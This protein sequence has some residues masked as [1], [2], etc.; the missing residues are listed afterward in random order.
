MIPSIVL[1]LSPPLCLATGY[2]PGKTVATLSV[3]FYVSTC[4]SPRPMK[5]TYLSPAIFISLSWKLFT[6]FWFSPSSPGSSPSPPH[7]RIPPHS[8]YHLCHSPLARDPQVI[9]RKAIP[10][11]FSF[12]FF[13]FFSTNFDLIWALFLPLKRASKTRPFEPKSAQIGA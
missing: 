10:P 7:P 3:S 11:Q 1:C 13:R 6:L 9:S 4:L 12:F 5:A 2:E 8:H